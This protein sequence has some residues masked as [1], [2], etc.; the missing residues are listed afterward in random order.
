MLSYHPQVYVV[1]DIVTKHQNLE[2][3]TL[4][5]L[6]EKKCIFC[7]FSAKKKNFSS[8]K[9]DE[10]QGATIQRK[11]KGFI[12]FSQNFSWSSKLL[13]VKVQKFHLPTT[14][15]CTVYCTTCILCLF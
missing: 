10:N 9:R 4:R 6:L 15:R 5:Y 8:K 14:C 3:G 7:F 2:I 11:K 12:S 13:N 1:R